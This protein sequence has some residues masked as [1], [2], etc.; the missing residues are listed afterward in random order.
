M[1]PIQTSSGRV[2]YRCPSYRPRPT[3]RPAASTAAAGRRPRI[4]GCDLRG[5]RLDGIKGLDSLAGAVIDPAQ[6]VTMAG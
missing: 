6:A 5:A 2:G 1:Q 3:R 4:S